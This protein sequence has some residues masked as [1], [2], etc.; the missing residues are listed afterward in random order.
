MPI[1]KIGIKPASI[2]RFLLAFIAFIGAQPASLTANG[3]TAPTAPPP[4]NPPANAHS[5]Y[6]LSY[7]SEQLDRKN[8]TRASA[9]SDAGANFNVAAGPDSGYLASR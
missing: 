6:S 9:G 2:Q 4:P 5:D 8:P 1:V 3:Q 7:L